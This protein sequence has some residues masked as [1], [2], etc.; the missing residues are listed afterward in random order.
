M[1]QD[2]RLSVASASAVEF[3]FWF[4]ALI[5]ASITCF[6]ILWR[7]WRRARIIED[8]PTS[9]IRSAAQGY[10][11]LIGSAELMDGE[12]IV[13]P[14]SGLPCTWYKYKV[15]EKQDI[16]IRGKHESRWRSIESGV[17]GEL[18]L[19]RDDSGACVVDPDGAEVT[20]SVSDSWYGSSRNPSSGSAGVMNFMDSGRY[21]YSESRIVPGDHLYAIGHFITHTATEQG[22]LNEDV[23]AI[24][25]LWKQY[26]DDHLKKFDTNGDGEIDIQEWNAVRSA[27]EKQALQDRAQ[28]VK[29]YGAIHMIKKDNNW[30]YLLSTKPQEK[31]VTRL[32]FFAALGMV[33]FFSLG[34]MA[35]WIF[36]IRMN[37]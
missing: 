9:K 25:R 19:I 20:P 17:S 32:R 2:F 26:P 1:I 21:R 31:L 5:I 22:S 14:L 35:T 37:T 30:P 7:F 24:L 15:E 12:P 8:V 18:F 34:T 23:K 13:G 36:L 29:D 28:R 27:A 11:E 10:V 16:S 3:Y 33:G 4:I 6:Y